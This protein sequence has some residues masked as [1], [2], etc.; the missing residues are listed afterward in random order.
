MNTNKKFS[1]FDF[2]L[3]MEENFNEIKQLYLSLPHKDKIDFNRFCNF[4]YRCS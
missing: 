4:V 3:F 2:I 1:E